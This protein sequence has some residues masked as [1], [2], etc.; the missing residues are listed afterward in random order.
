MTLVYGT[1]CFLKLQP[2]ISPYHG[3]LIKIRWTRQRKNCKLLY[4]I[5]IPLP[6]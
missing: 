1:G 2:L 5:N 6:R 4:L 3:F